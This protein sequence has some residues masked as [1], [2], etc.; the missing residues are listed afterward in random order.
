M[1]IL[2]DGSS[3]TKHVKAA[4]E[5]CG[6][7]CLVLKND[8]SKLRNAL[9]YAMKAIQADAVYFVFVGARSRRRALAKA[10]RK[11]IIL[12]WIGTDVLLAAEQGL[13][14]FTK[15]TCLSLAGSELLRNELAE[16]GVESKVIPIVPADM[17]FEPIPAPNQHAVMV[18]APETREDFYGMPL[19]EQLAIRCPHITFHIVANT[20]TSNRPKPDN[21]VFEGFLGAEDM[22]SLYRKCSILFRYP[23]HDGLSMMVLEAL[24]VGR[25]VIY[26][27]PFPYAK[28]PASSSI[29]DIA[30]SL[31][32]LLAFPPTVNEE[33]VAYIRTEYSLERQIRRYK[34]TGL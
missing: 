30:A 28:T 34:E 14:G 16:I 5:Q 4:L 29:D 25:S 20:G 21:I 9:D 11:Q 15:D 10:L 33:A 3:Q 22:L 19:V 32:E 31:E 2:L 6:H 7:S 23:E 13:D 18:Y 17:A 26:K 27:Y 12:H 24:G 1:K 8:K